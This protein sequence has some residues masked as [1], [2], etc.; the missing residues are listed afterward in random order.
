[1]LANNL[2]AAREQ[3]AFT[4]GFHII[5]VPFG[6]AFP[7]MVLVAEWRGW[8]RGDADAMKLARRW[9]KVMAVL[10]AVGAVTG[11]VLSFEMGLLWPGLFDRFGAVIG[12]PFAIEGLAFFVEAIFVGIYLYGW[13]RLSP[14]A[15]FLSGVPIVLSGVLGTVAVISA[16]AWMN[17]PAGFKIAP[18][19]SIIDIDPLGAMFNKAMGYE[20]PHMLI[21][22]YMVAGFTVASIYAVG[23]LRGNRT[24]Y[25]RIGFIIPFVIAAVAA[26]LQVVVGDVAARGVFHDQPSKFA[27]MELV[28]TSGPNQAMHLGGVLIDGE[29]VGAFAIPGLDS[30]L[31]GFSTSTEVT[32]LDQ[33][34][35]DERAPQ[36]IVHLAFQLMVMIGTALVALGAWFGF[37]WWRKRRLPE[38]TWFWR[39]AAVAGLG[40]IAAL[41]AGW[42]TTEVG[43][44]PWIAYK[45]M[46][47]EDAVTTNGGLWWTYG[48]LV[49][50]YAGLGT[51][52]VLVIRRMA[53][54]WRRDDEEPAPAGALVG[55]GR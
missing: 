47:V 9:S 16:N 5:L 55:V 30:L 46:R 1:M 18:D 38:S 53:R 17:Q 27:A 44:Q 26:P 23:W 7:C 13:K 48:L 42:I 15:H 29:V 24:R 35:V 40:S 4:L 28:T 21:A 50:L 32:G 14:R 19:G 20:A 36:N 12:V 49:V 54:Q 2:L 6:V 3:M 10:F 41:E 33:I 34:P 37:V 43:R 45:L 25:H 51:A 11:T 31:A 39:A 52:T 8:K 22:A